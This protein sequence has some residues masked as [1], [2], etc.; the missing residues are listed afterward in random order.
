[1]PNCEFDFP[2]SVYN[3]YDCL[4]A[5]VGNDKNAIVLD[6][7][8]GSGTTAH[9]LL[10]LNKEDNGNRKFI[11]C[12]QMHYVDTITKERVKQV[13]KNDGKGSFVYMEL[14]QWNEKYMQA[15][16]EAKTTKE[17][18]A[19]YKKMQAEAFFR[20]E[21]DLNKFDQKQF[22]Q[23]GLDDQKKVLLECLDKNH[24]YINFSEIEDAT[25][26]IPAEEKKINKQFYS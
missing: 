23:L 2:K 19:I 13:I 21:I 4:Y 24:L 8:A 12:E 20:Y 18:A 25:Y 6:F 3:V 26:K 11:L 16:Q 14:S 7:F 9:A 1:M 17:L 22:E 15:I 5:V 10:M